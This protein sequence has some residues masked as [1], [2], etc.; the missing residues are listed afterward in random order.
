MKRAGGFVDLTRLRPGSRRRR[1]TLLR[2]LAP[3]LAVIAVVA[4]I[5]WVVIRSLP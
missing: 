1:L 3:P 2:L 5:A 4:I